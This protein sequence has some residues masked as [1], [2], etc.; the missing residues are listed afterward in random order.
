MVAGDN[1]VKRRLTL[2]MNFS[3][4]QLGSRVADESTL[5]R[6]RIRRLGSIFWVVTVMVT[7]AGTCRDVL[8][9]SGVR[10]VRH[11]T[12]GLT[13]TP[14]PFRGKYPPVVYVPPGTIVFASK[15]SSLHGYIAI[16]THYGH[17]VQVQ[18][19]MDIDGTPNAIL[20]PIEGLVKP[21][22]SKQILFH[23][24]ILCLGQT[25]RIPTPPTRCNKIADNPLSVF[26]VGKGWVYTFKESR[27]K[28][29]WVDLRVRLDASTR[30]KLE[31]RGLV[32]AE[33]NFDIRRSELVE[34]EKRGYL[35]M[36]DKDHPIRRF[37]YTTRLPVYIECGQERVTEK[38]LSVSTKV[39][40]ETGVDVGAPIWA[41]WIAGVKAKL[42]LT[43]EAG[44]ESSEQ[45]TWTIAV[46]T[47]E[48]SYLYYMATMTDPETSR[49]ASIFI[50]KIFDCEPPP[51][52]GP[53]D[54]IRRVS[55]TI[56]DPDQPD[57]HVIEFDNP[58]DYLPVP[59]AL[60]DHHGRPIFIS[61]NNPAQHES[62]MRTIV[63]T[64]KIGAD[65]AHFIIAN[66]NYA[67]TSRNNT[68][69]TCAQ[70]VDAAQP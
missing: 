68:R 66:I 36:L 48:A 10:I 12:W 15:P 13:M 70:L 11:G 9:D 64:K 17:W 51:T 33:A 40:G 45:T 29:E 5:R 39:Q 18:E 56:D 41:K 53:G 27:S 31:S 58:S 6:R 50:E 60:F 49:Q 3:R 59:E 55:F 26:P 20:R 24:S 67:C 35:T 62:V 63:E 19:F 69:D 32:P 22:R 23:S 47:K 43:V 2:R 28:P 52:R 37:E 44:T 1:S 54:R 8:A 38:A 34:L 30:E 65:L 46:D 57:A 61:I 14:D 4:S 16:E 42:G 7:P 25:N 21:P